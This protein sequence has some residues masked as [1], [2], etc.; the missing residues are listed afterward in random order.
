MVLNNQTKKTVT[1]EKNGDTHVGR[2][3]FKRVDHFKT[4]DK[5]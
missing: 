1:L 5:F 2:S 3:L 4:Y